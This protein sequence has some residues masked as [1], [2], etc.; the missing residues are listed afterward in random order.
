MKYNLKILDV[1]A[2]IVSRDGY[3]LICRRSEDKHLAGYWEFPGGKIEQN[4]GHKDCLQR[5]LL[6]ELGVDSA[7]GEFVAEVTHHYVDRII[8]LYAYEAEIISSEIQLVDHDTYKWV[9]PE[10]VLKYQL[11]PADIPILCTSLNQS[12]PVSFK[13]KL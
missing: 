9:R 5:E 6:E 12:G 4:E 11:A 1:V 8:R 13:V 2:G 3:L 7:I 10:E